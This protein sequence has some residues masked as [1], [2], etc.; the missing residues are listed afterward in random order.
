MTVQ[1]EKKAWIETFQIDKD[2]NLGKCDFNLIHTIELDPS[3]ALSEWLRADLN[4]YLYSSAPSIK[5]VTNE[6]DET[7]R[8]EVELDEDG[9]PI[10]K[11]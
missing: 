3:L 4:V 10:A 6:E 1:T 11:K 7:T 5:K 2:T 9:Q 8:D